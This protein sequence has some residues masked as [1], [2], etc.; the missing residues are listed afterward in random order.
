MKAITLWQ[1]WA[2]LVA[3]GAKSVETRS[4]WTGHR[5]LL[6]IH[7][8]AALRLAHRDLCA[9]EPF[10]AALRRAGLTDPRA[11]PLGGVI[12]VCELV[13]CSLIRRGPE[14]F[15]GSSE[16]MV[17]PSA[18]ELAFGDWTPGRYAWCL[19]NVRALPRPIPA[20]G[21]QGLWEWPVP[22]ELEEMV[23]G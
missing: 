19:A 1:P 21:R 5:G 20:R 2:G 12:A 13:D 16:R 18:Q 17:R 4:W 11:L 9:E 22:P 8:G 14:A 6:A 10:R 3:I 23:A 7:A 15:L